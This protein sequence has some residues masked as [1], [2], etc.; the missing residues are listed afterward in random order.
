[1][2]VLALLLALK[3]ANML[4]FCWAFIDFILITQYYSPD[5]AT[6]KYLDQML[7]KI[8]MYKEAL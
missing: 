2:P 7:I 5:N 8:N 1:M 3:H 6:L 4:D